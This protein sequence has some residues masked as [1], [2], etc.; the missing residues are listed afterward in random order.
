MQSLLGLPE[1]DPETPGRIL[2]T[3]RWSHQKSHDRRKPPK[4][5]A[6][7]ILGLAL[8]G[9]WPFSWSPL[10]YTITCWTVAKRSVMFCCSRGSYSWVLYI[11]RSNWHLINHVWCQYHVLEKKR[12][13]TKLEHCTLSRIS[14]SWPCLIIWLL[15]MNSFPLFSSI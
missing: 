4:G 7:T 5:P 1:S 13:R 3:N 11:I 14:V 6:M 12:T 15:C 8:I 9:L 10:V 2:Q